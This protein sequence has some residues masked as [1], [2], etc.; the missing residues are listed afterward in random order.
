MPDQPKNRKGKERPATAAADDGSKAPE[1]DAA[2]VSEQPL[3]KLIDVGVLAEE[4]AALCADQ[5]DVAEYPRILEAI[6]RA[7]SDGVEEVIQI[8]DHGAPATRGA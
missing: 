5:G 4:L 1:T 2:P 7:V 6:S 8:L 3:H